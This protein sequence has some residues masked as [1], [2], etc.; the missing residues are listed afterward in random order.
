LN[1]YHQSAA[2]APGLEPV[3][4]IENSRVN[5]HQRTRTRLLFCALAGWISQGVKSS[6]RGRVLARPAFVANCNLFA[7]NGKCGDNSFLAQ[8]QPIKSTRGKNKEAP[9]RQTT[10]LPLSLK[11]CAYKLYKVHGNMQCPLVTAG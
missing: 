1:N 7:A 3:A 11:Y 8:F 2:A 6:A 5:Q 4:R 10:S 9:G